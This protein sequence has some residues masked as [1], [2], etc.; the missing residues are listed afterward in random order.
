MKKFILL[1]LFSVWLFF[2]C[3]HYQS[4]SS[5][6]PKLKSICLIDRNGISETISHI[7]RLKQYEKINFLCSQPY[8]KI[9]RI[10]HRNPNG[11]IRALVN[12]YYPNGQSKQYLEVVNSRA[13]GVYM[14]WHEN[15][16]RKLESFVIGGE[17]D[18]NPSAENSWLFDGYTYSWSDEG[19]L[20]ATIPY[21]KGALQGESLYYHLNGRIW[22][23]VPFSDNEIHG[24][25]EIYLETGELLQ[26]TKYCKGKKSGPSS[27]YWN[28]DRLASDEIYDDD[29]LLQGV[30]YDST[31]T[32]ISEIKDG[33]GYKAIFGKTGICELQEYQRGIQ[34]GA[35]QVFD[36]NK[37]TR[38][39][40]IKNNNKHGEDIEYDDQSSRKELPKLL[41]TWHEGKIQ[42]IVKTWYDNGVQES[43]REMSNN[44]KNGLSTAW[45]RDGSLML[46]EEYENNKLLKGEYYSRAEKKPISIV[47]EGKGLATLFDSEG[48]FLKKVTY[49]KGVPS[50][51]S[52]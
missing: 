4:S 11:D 50:D 5:T 32:L 24:S 17:P 51:D 21:E 8:Q 14:E 18:I 25:F 15:G 30:Y 47:R 38:K 33:N 20:L 7:E 34:E 37:L 48:N 10:Y 13:C 46:L 1:L 36:Q 16:I 39:Y 28:L 31:G 22:K 23:K 41:I 40:Y 29:L 52:L 19:I 6:Q 45:Y 49:D 3:Q 44:S 12:S 27:R 9:L 42:G 2:G 43:N 35:V 26:Q